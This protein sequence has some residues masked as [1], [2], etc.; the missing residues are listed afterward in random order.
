LVD[1][2]DQAN[3]IAELFL[4]AAL[5]KVRR[6]VEVRGYGLCFNCGDEVEGETRWCSLDCRADYEKR[7]RRK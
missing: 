7:E 5:D 3:D 1:E 2:A 4:R 6:P